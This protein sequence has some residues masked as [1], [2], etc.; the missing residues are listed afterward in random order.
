[1]EL[2]MTVYYEPADT[3]EEIYSYLKEKKTTD[4]PSQKIR[5]VSFC[6]YQ[7]TIYIKIS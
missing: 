7:E 6:Q 5:S 4:I 2:V 1:M 3:E